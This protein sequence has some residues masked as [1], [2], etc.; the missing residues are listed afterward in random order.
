MKKI[1]LISL[2]ACFSLAQAAIVTVD[3]NYVP[4]FGGDNSSNSNYGGLS[5]EI[6]TPDGLTIS[7][8]GTATFDDSL[9]APGTTVGDPFVMTLDGL[10]DIDFTVTGIPEGSTHFSKNDLSGWILVVNAAGIIQ[11]LNFFRVP[12]S[13]PVTPFNADGYAVEG[14]SPLVLGLFNASGQVASFVAAPTVRAPIYAVPALST[15]GLFIL[16]LLV[17]FSFNRKF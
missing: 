5:H 12:V 13:D 2:L 11:D 6:S 4:E 1:L 14:T 15:T 10:V 9:L 17:G 16:M 7:F 8:T 3:M